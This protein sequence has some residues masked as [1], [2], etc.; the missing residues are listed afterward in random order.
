MKKIIV[1]NFT[2]LLKSLFLFFAPIKGIII[3]VALSTIIDTCFGIWKAKKLKE[4]VNSKT[5]RFGFVPKLM[6]YVGA[7]MLVYASDFFII[8][9]LTKEVIS[10]DYLATKLIAL[11]LIS[12]EVKSM[13]ESFQKVKG[14]SFISKIVKLIIQAK[15]VKKKLAE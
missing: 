14:Y 9:Y 6:S 10:V 1:A 15:D 13:D 3:L 12:I 2:T 5:F 11:M 7:I 8:N 4:K